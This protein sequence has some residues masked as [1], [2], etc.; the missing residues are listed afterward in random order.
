MEAKIYS[1]TSAA[2]STPSTNNTPTM[3]SMSVHVIAKGLYPSF[4]IHAVYRNAAWA[5]FKK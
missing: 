4:F 2:A 1:R 3:T 5:D